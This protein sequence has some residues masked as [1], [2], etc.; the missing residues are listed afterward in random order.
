[1]TLFSML[2]CTNATPPSRIFN[3]VEFGALGNGVHDDSVAFQAAFDAMGS[4]PGQV[5]IPTGSFLLTQTI[6]V[7]SPGLFSLRGDGPG[8]N[9]LW[10]TD[11]T[12]L[13]FTTSSPIGMA[14][15]A[16]FSV[17]SI[18][19]SKSASST[20]LAFPAGFTKSQIHSVQLIGAGGLPS[21]NISETIPIGSGFDLG[22]VT[23]TVMLHNCL[24]WFGC[25]T[26]I[27]IGRGSEVRVS[28]GRF[29]GNKN[30]GGPSNSI[31]VHVTGNTGGV[32]IVSTDII[33]WGTGMQLDQ[34]NGKGSNREI[35]IS[36]GTLDSNGRGLA[37]FDNSYVSIAGC[38]AASSDLDNIWTDPSSNPQL[39][40]AGGTIFNA[41]SL[42]DDCGDDQ[43][44]GLTVNGGTFVLSGVEVRYNKGIGTPGQSQCVVGTPGV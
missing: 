22:N 38:W 40:I 35:F 10:S 37:V 20:A 11:K 2:M 5:Y 33:S 34:S 42:S 13:L 32:H 16:D 36:H 24:L 12:L 17:S 4:L 23:D 31:G 29:I 15:I 21:G 30:D 43:C 27:K 3:V 28:G 1:M 18:N 19:Q 41:G 14:T 6:Y 44:N 25:G 8:S 39:S 7:K 26:G 9:L